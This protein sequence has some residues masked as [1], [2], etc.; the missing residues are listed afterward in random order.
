MTGSNNPINEA[1][2]RQSK[3]QHSLKDVEVSID[4]ASIDDGSIDGTNPV[5]FW[6]AQRV[7]RLVD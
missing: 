3:T 7:A 5:L 1:L 6:F 2:D 4:D